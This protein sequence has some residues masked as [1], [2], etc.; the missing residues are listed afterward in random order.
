MC[1]YVY[2]YVSMYLCMYLCIYDMY[3]MYIRMYACL[4]VCLIAGVC[5]NDNIPT[6]R[7]TACLSSCP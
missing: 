1:I 7:A 5:Q 6:T 2:M 3:D 4:S